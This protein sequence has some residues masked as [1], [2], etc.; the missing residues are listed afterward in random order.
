VQ[1]RLLKGWSYK[2]IAEDLKVAEGTIM[3]YAS[4][5]YPQHQ[6]HSREELAR[7]F[8]VALDRA[9]SSSRSVSAN[10]K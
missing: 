8:G 7:K 10:P 2:Q 5:V 6:V 3:G 1:E 9:R 4:R